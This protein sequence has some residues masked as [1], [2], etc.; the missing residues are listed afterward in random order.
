MVKATQEKATRPALKPLLDAA[1]PGGGNVAQPDS[2]LCQTWV[3]N[4]QKEPIQVYRGQHGS[5]PMQPDA[6]GLQSTLA[7]ITFTSDPSVASTYA[8]QPNDWRLIPIAPCVLLAYL[9][10]RN[11]VFWLEDD[12]FVDFSVLSFAL[13]ADASLR[14]ARKFSAHVEDT[15]LWAEDLSPLFKSVDDFL[16]KYPERV[17]EL[18]VQAWVLLDDFEF[19]QTAKDAGFDGAMSLG[20][21]ESATIDEYRIFDAAQYK[22]AAQWHAA[23]DKRIDLLE[24]FYRENQ[25]ASVFA[26]EEEFQKN[27]L[28][29]EE[30]SAFENVEDSNSD[31]DDLG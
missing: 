23:V 30:D 16:N 29:L 17:G 19:V 8:M 7:S 15:N 3:V 13:G 9:D 6:V 31:E 22:P 14:F 2:W 5:T 28:F 10:I 26:E 21:G 1:T 27:R 18:C 4:E 12:P 11:P 25:E 20:S 24:Q